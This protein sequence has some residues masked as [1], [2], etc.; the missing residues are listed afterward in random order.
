MLGL[1][2]RIEV[3]ASL[4]V[5]VSAAMGVSVV[6]RFIRDRDALDRKLRKV[7]RQLQKLRDEI[8]AKQGRIQELQAAVDMLK[9]L[10]AHLRAYHEQLLELHV[11]QERKAMQEGEKQK[12]GEEDED[13]WDV[14]RKRIRLDR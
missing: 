9:P 13:G 14:R 2:L 5:A 6:L 12:G 8:A 1:L 10:E 11:E 7:D 4:V 3:I